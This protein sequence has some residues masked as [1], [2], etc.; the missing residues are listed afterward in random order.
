MTDEDKNTTPTLRHNLRVE[1]Y[2]YQ[3]EGILF[4]ACRAI[5]FVKSQSTHQMVA[6]FGEHLWRRSSGGNR[7]VAVKLA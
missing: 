6:Y 7:Y 3:R 2:P 5:I 4:E 1:P